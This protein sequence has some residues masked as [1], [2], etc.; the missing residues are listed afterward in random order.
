MAFGTEDYAISVWGFYYDIVNINN[1]PKLK[2]KLNDYIKT[3][4]RPEIVN[5]LEVWKKK[6]PHEAMDPGNVE[7]ESI[8]IEKEMLP[9]LGYFMKQL[10]EDNGFG[11]YKSE[12]DGEYD[13]WD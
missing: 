13:K 3:E 10:L 4:W 5:K 1:G 6:N 7:F 8:C 11:F 12:F 2:D 9:E